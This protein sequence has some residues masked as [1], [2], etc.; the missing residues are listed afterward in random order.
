M[1]AAQQG[2]ADVVRV[3]LDAGGDVNAK[4]NVSGC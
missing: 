3:L 1:S 4:R 2:H